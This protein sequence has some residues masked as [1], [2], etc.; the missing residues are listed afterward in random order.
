MESNMVKNE[1][2]ILSSKDALTLIRM[3]FDSNFSKIHLVEVTDK[4][5]F[6][7][8]VKYIYKNIAI[9]FGCEKGYISAE[10]L[11]N[12]QCFN[13]REW[14]GFTN[15]MRLLNATE[16]NIYTLFNVV[17]NT[18]NLKINKNKK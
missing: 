12:Q 5:I 1:D 6:F 13:M 15:E 4:G 10:I 7:Y 16:K 18:I 9:N 11:I 17:M 2:R 3:L 14:I 8:Q